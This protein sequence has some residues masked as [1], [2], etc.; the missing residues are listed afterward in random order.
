[1]LQK[2][3]AFS[4]YQYRSVHFSRIHWHRR[5]ADIAEYYRQQ[6]EGL[7]AMSL[8]ATAVRLPTGLRQ[9]SPATC[10]ASVARYGQPREK[11]SVR[12]EPAGHELS[13]EPHALRLACLPLCEKP[14]RSVQ[15]QVGARHPH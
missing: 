9:A 6:R 4:H 2:F 8:G 1:L 15:V 3:S 11:R 13:E 7:T 14:E 10:R 12:G 5:T